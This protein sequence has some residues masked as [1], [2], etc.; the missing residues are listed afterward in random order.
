MAISELGSAASLPLQNDRRPAANTG[1]TARPEREP[2]SERQPVQAATPDVQVTLSAEAQ[3]LAVSPQQQVPNVDASTD[4]Q[5]EA[6]T[7][8]AESPE[9]PSQRPSAS[10]ALGTNIDIQA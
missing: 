2:A 9:A 7:N 8:T 6:P 4:T 5:P 10:D 1:S 3:N